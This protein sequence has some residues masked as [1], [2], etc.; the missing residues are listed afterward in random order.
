MKK[1]KCPEYATWFRSEKKF[2]KVLLGG[3]SQSSAASY[4]PPVCSCANQLDRVRSFIT[5]CYV[6][7]VDEFE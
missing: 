7:L 3:A 5:I 2:L 4:L 6:C 1:L